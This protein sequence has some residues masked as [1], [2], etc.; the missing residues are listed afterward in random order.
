M[1]K[2]E[3]RRTYV[4]SMDYGPNFVAIQIS[5]EPNQIKQAIVK[6]VRYVIISNNEY[7][8][9]MET[10]DGLCTPIKGWF[11]RTDCRIEE[12]A[13]VKAYKD[14]LSGDIA[15]GVMVTI[16]YNANGIMKFYL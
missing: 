11:W 10:E 1:D 9:H 2:K 7:Q 6:S 12:Q 13:F 4:K 16:E 14:I 5:P 3:N 8:L 15:E